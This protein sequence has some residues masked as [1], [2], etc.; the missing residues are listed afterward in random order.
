MGTNARQ[1][2]RENI[3]DG[4]SMKYPWIENDEAIYVMPDGSWHFAVDH[5]SYMG[6][7]YC[8]VDGGFICETHGS[9][10]TYGCREC[11]MQGI[12]LNNILR[13]GFKPKVGQIMNVEDQLALVEGTQE[14]WL[15]EGKQ[16]K[17]KVGQR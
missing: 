11:L 2:L 9:W 12:N 14:V 5:T 7:D 4:V 8:K 10:F 3:W 6:D 15:V 13:I 16:F 1:K 17:F